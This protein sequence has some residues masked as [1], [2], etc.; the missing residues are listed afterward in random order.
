MSLSRA[1]RLAHA[2]FFRADTPHFFSSISTSQS[3]LH[4]MPRSH[5]VIALQFLF[6]LN[7]ARCLVMLENPQLTWIIDDSNC[8]S[9][10][11]TNA[12]NFTVHGAWN[13]EISQTQAQYDAGVIKM[14]QPRVSCFFTDSTSNSSLV[15][16][17]WSC[18]W[19]A[20]EREEP[21]DLYVTIVHELQQDWSFVKVFAL[22]ESSRPYSDVWGQFFVGKVRHRAHCNCRSSRALKS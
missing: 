12:I 22:V 17:R 19:L 9:S 2:H 16:A 15:S 3:S 20:P 10:I 11:V 4:M 5:F 6:C 18:P 1:L 8:S 14:L 21:V 7:A 13:I